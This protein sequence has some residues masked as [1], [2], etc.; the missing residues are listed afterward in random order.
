MSLE[1]PDEWERYAI[2]ENEFR[3][4]S[5]E[6]LLDR[7]AEERARDYH[8]WPG[9][10]HDYIDGLAEDGGISHEDAMAH[11]I[12]T[13][14][15]V[16]EMREWARVHTPAGQAGE[17]SPVAAV[18]LIERHYPDGVA[19]WR[20]RPRPAEPVPLLRSLAR[21]VRGLFQRWFC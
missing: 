10:L 13:R 6:A 17:A 12:Y 3:H 16:A 20:R 11:A 15:G 7:A 19:G 18:G 14:E 1:W 9:T 8:D 4:D 5:R 21:K 2:A